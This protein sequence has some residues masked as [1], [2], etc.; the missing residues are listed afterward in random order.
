MPKAKHRNPSSG[1]KSYEVI[2]RTQT[3]EPGAC[4]F[5]DVLATPGRIA[6]QALT[7]MLKAQEIGW[8]AARSAMKDDIGRR[9]IA[10]KDDDIWLLKC[11]P[12]CWRL[13]FYVWEK[14]DD[15]RLIYVHAVCKQTDE[16]DPADLTTARAVL[17]SIRSGGRAIT[18]F[19]F[20]PR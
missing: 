6:K 20:P 3:G 11:K 5:S 17:N 2:E 4:P 1:W 8:P 19:E 16:E 9:L 15:K 10:K 12:S 14:E 7:K 18:P 13:Y